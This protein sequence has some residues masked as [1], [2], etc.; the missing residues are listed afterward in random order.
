MNSTKKFAL[1]TVLIFFTL[2]T[3]SLSIASNE[4]ES[5][6]PVGEFGAF[7]ISDNED[8]DLLLKN[9]YQADVKDINW[10]LTVRIDSNSS[11]AV[12][13]TLF[14][15]SQISTISGISEF[16]IEPG[17]NRSV[18]YLHEYIYRSV[19]CSCEASPINFYFELLDATKEASGT[20]EFLNTVYDSFPPL[21]SEDSSIEGTN[22]SNHFNNLISPSTTDINTEARLDG[23]TLILLL[24][25]V[26]ALFPLA[27]KRK[28]K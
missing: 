24:L 15:N 19:V 6:D 25:N 3:E 1:I 23:F 10:S 5:V 17:Q 20:F 14:H 27:L 21:N 8:Q 28:N 2:H 12:K 16:T 11:S 9:Y 22:E 7:F 18:M 26:I 13:F 4:D